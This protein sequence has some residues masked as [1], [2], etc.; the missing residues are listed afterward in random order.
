G[1]T[2]DRTAEHPVGSSSSFT[3]T[4]PIDNPSFLPSPLITQQSSSSYRL[5]LS[6]LDGDEKNMEID[7]QLQPQ[8]QQ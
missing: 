1:V 5:R 3:T 8:S 4:P 2:T 7:V 6:P